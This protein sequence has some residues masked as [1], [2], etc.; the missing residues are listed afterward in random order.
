LEME[1]LKVDVLH[2]SLCKGPAGLTESEPFWKPS[3]L[4]FSHTGL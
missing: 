4:V 3:G 1:S 2:S